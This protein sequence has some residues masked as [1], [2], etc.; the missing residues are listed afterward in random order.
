MNRSSSGINIVPILIVAVVCIGGGL[1]ISTLTPT[2]FPVQASSQAQQI[3]TLFQL[4]LAIGGG[5]F[6]LVQGLI[7]YAAFRFRVKDENDRSDGPPIHGNNTLEIV[8]TAIPAVVVVILVIYSYSVW[9]S[10]ETPQQNETTV[11]VVGRRFAWTFTYTAEDIIDPQTNAPVR[12]NDPNLYT[13]VNEALRLQMTATDVNHAF[14]VP[15]MRIKQ[16]L[17]VGRITEMRF[18]PI[19]STDT[20]GDGIY[21]MAEAFPLRCAELCGDGHGAMGLVSHVYVFGSREEYDN[22][23]AQRVNLVLNPP[24]DPVARGAQILPTYPCSGC[25]VLTSLGWTGQSG[26]NLNGIGDRASRRVAGDSA[27]EYIVHSI[28]HPL[29]YLVPGYAGIMPQF[30][31]DDPSNANYMSDADLIAITAYLCTQTASGDS[32]CDISTI[33]EAAA[34][35]VTTSGMASQ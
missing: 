32:A 1:L 25:H 24:E 19:L 28:R 33:E 20:N 5:L 11:E 13:Y 15:Q 34:E 29:R 7:Y 22:W 2:L 10:I 30:I 17:L 3:D 16:D 23:F 8:W 31:E 27:E 9:V 35:E 14:W 12:F 26:P 4:M 21:E 18:T 6:L